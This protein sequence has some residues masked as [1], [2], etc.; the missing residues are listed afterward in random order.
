MQEPTG[1][2]SGDELPAD[3]PTGPGSGDELPADEPT[4]PG[5]GDELPA[6]EPTGPGSGDEV[7]SDEPTGPGSGDEVSADEPTGPGSGDEIPA[8]EPTGP[9]SGD[10]IP[11]D[12]PTGPGSGDEII[13]EPTGPGSGEEAKVHASCNAI[14]RASTCIDYIGSFWSFLQ[15]TELNCNGVGAHST[16]PCPQPSVGGCNVSAGTSNEIV[17]W[18][19]DYGGDPF[20]PDVV[21][22]AAM[23]CNANPMASWLAN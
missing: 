14:G 22:Y 11:A 16:E 20:T 4:G 1:P 5:Y 21:P 19:Y 10:E 18:H 8:D 12:E 23:T 7:P 3:E 17:I 13:E 6:D 15:N 2:G 9:G